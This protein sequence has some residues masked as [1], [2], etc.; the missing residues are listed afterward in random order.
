MKK[1]ELTVES[2][3]VKS[4]FG[5]V[6]EVFRVKALKDFECPIPIAK[7]DLGGW[8]ESENN[9][10]Q[11]GNCWIMDNA[12]CLGNGKITE[13]VLVGGVAVIDNEILSGT[14][15]IG[16]FP[17]QGNPTCCYIDFEET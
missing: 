9:L 15:C 13:N 6:T 16:A 1:Y 8:I 4:P 11:E 2:K 5:I 7:G 17:T 12:I 3:K 10:S 14:D